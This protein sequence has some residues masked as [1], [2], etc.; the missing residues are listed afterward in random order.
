MKRKE[1][2]KLIEA[3]NRFAIR[4]GRVTVVGQLDN[5][6]VALLLGWSRQ[7]VNRAEKIIMRKLRKRMQLAGHGFESFV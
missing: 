5:I 3:D 1:L 2:K 4:R 7:R 6:E